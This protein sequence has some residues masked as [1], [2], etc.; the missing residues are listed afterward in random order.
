MVSWQQSKGG[1][2]LEQ[3]QELG[4]SLDWDRDQ[5]TLSTHFRKAVDT[6]FIQLFDQGLIYRLVC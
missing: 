5:F 2:I 4:A 1:R 6:A 3:L